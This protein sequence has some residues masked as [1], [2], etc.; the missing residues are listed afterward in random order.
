MPR[1]TG[2]PL[3][4]S[5]RKKIVLRQWFD[6]IVPCNVVQE[7]MK[8]AG[9]CRELLA[10]LFIYQIVCEG[11]WSPLKMRKAENIH[12][13]FTMYNF[14][15]WLRLHKGLMQ[16]L[17]IGQVRWSHILF[18]CII[19]HIN[20]DI[21]IND[22][23][24]FTTGTYPRNANIEGFYWVQLMICFCPKCMWTCVKSFLDS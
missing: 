19:Y 6:W 12:F 11:F 2:L 3:I 20:V 22:Y 21:Q 23:K 14:D 8:I 15:A 13:L 9:A 18:P 7:M 1:N 10:L 24:L 17:S 16:Y 4:K 5:K